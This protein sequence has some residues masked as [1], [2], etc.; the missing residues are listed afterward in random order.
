MG[1]PWGRPSFKKNHIS[2]DKFR[3]RELL[4]IS[5]R[6]IASFKKMHI[7]AD[8]F[9]DREIL[10]IRVREIALLPESAHFR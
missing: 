7:S 8:K 10:G 6:E 5:V 1:G 2:A 9:K 3:D 4:G